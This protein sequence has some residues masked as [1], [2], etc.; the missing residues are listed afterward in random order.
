MPKLTRRDALAS[1]AVAGTGLVAA[2]AG[3]QE[4]PAAA[5][6]TFK[7]AQYTVKTW[8]LDDLDFRLVEVF[9][10]NVSIAFENLHLN[11]ELGE[12]QLE[13][14]CML[15]GA[16]ESRSKET[17]NHVKRVGLIAEGP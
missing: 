6:A 17:A 10:T 4:K 15:A 9:C 1:M 12:A 3:A 2:A 16:A 11:R 5:A 8:K 7:P 13:T 14:I